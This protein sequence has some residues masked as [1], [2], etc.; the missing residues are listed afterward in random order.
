[1]KIHKQGYKIII[2][3]L[4]ILS[5]IVVII[6]L[7][8]PIQ[9]YIHYFL[10]LSG[11]IFYFMIV[12]FFRSPHR[13]IKIDEKNILSA[14]DGKIV[15][16]E[17][18]QETE[19]FKDK[20]IQVSVFMSPL[21]IHVN[22]YPVGGIVKYKKYHPGSY[23]IASRP[24]SSFENEMTSI[25][26]QTK[27]KQEILIRQIAGFVARRIISHAKQG[28]NVIQGEELGIIKFGSRVDL[29]LPTDVNIKV[30]LNQKVRGCETVIAQFNK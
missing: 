22:W 2:I 1:M 9:T 10:Y 12:R 15:V 7:L 6:N 5:G 20:R 28:N 23:F 25:I 8:F 4:F 27:Q 29:F 19:Y 11:I 17:E 14:A 13:K 26:I 30:K 3:F 24:K 16:I 21:D 18:I